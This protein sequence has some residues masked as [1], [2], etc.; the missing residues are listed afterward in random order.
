MA[1]APLTIFMLLKTTPTWLALAPKARFAFLD[2]TIRPLLQAAEGIALRYYDAEAFT[3]RV[4]DIAVW[5][6]ASLDAWQ[7]FAEKLRE[8]PF[9][10]TYFQV[11]DILPA[12]ENAYA[13][14]YGVVPIDA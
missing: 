7:A 9:W 11:L 13:R 4:S 12:I 10:D 3:A 8:T 1:H 14:H 2:S 6:V 5:D